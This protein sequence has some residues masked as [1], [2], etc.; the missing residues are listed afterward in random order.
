MRTSREEAAMRPLVHVV[1]I[2]VNEDLKAAERRKARRAP[3]RQATPV[4]APPAVVRPTASPEPVT[5]NTEVVRPR[6][7]ADVRA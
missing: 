3:R 6:K 5:R 4:V 2:L 1:K 7:A